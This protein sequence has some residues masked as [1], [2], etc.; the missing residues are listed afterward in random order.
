MYNV[1]L[2]DHS[3]FPCLIPLRDGWNKKEVPLPFS[4]GTIWAILYQNDL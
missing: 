4:K 2:A 1:Q 3:A